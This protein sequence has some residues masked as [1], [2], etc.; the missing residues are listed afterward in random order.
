MRYVKWVLLFAAVALAVLW[1]LGW[2]APEP[3]VAINRHLKKLTELASFTASEPSF[4]RF[5]KIKQLSGLFSE[6]SVI[7]VETMGVESHT[8]NG[9]DELMQAM[10]A[11]KSF[12]NG[13]KAEFVDVNIELGS[14]NQSALVELTL[15]ARLG[16]ESEMIAQEFKFTFKKT[17]REWY[18]TRVDSVR[19]LK[20]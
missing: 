14:G 1:L 6:D 4:Q 5:S 15:K 3:K 2:F 9:R 13:L 11:A 10:M 20:P 16:G 12:A 8:L 18:I 7:V 19:T 17:K